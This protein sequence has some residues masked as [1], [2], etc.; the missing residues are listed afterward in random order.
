MF[1]QR[2]PKFET[3]IKS[4]T[5]YFANVVVHA[6][7]AQ[8][9]AGNSSADRE[10]GRKFAD[11]LCSRDHDLVSKDQFFTSIEKFRE[12]VDDLPGAGEP[13]IVR[14]NSA[15]TEA[16]VVA[17]HTR[18]GERFEQIENFLALAERV[19]EWRTPRSHIAQQK[20]QERR[21]VLQPSE[22]G[23]NDAQVF[24]ALRNFDAGEFLYTERVG[25]VVAHRTKV[26]EPIG[27]RHRAEIS[28][29]L[30]DL[31]MVAMQIT[32]DRFE[33]ADDFAFKRDVHPKHAMG[34]WMLQP[35]RDFE[36]LAFQP[37]THGY[38]GPLHGFESLSNCSHAGGR[39]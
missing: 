9:W 24:G 4:V 36:Q 28:C 18:A 12:T 16:H 38:G 2:N 21:V 10:I 15:A 13:I 22:F 7:R 32:E 11:V 23:E 3:R 26:I 8:H 17:H 39:V 27:V 6:A 37:G 35:H 20:P 5:V 33:F 19:H 25:P 34:R 29:L 1:A 31:L 30:A 14:I